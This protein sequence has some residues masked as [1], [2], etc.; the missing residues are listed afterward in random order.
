MNDPLKAVYAI[1]IT[2]YF[3]IENYKR[4]I[5]NHEITKRFPLILP[6]I[7]LRILPAAT[8]TPINLHVIFD[9]SLAVTEIEDRF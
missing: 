2:D 5:S 1:G 3:S 4:V 6:N 9:P 8:E 7:E